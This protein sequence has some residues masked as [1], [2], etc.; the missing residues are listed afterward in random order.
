[1]KTY[2]DCIPCF[3]D[4]ALRAGRISGMNE[5]LVKKLLD[6]VGSMIK[7]LPLESSPPATGDLIYK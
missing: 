1:M 2:L 5:A 4:Q 6:E 7:D 3:M